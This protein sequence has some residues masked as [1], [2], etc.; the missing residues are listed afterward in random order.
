M[1]CGIERWILLFALVSRMQ[2]TVRTS[3]EANSVVI[4]KFRSFNKQ[5]P[6]TNNAINSRMVP[7]AGFAEIHVKLFSA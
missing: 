2:Y 5:Y 3:P 6:Q 4:I 7:C 1:E